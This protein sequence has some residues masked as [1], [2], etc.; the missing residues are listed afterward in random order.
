MAEEA[1]ILIIDDEEV[2]RESCCRILSEEGHQIETATDGERGLQKVKQ[3]KPDLALVDLKMPGM[4]GIEILE[5]IQDIDPDIVSIVITGYATIESAVEAMKR[6]AYDFIPKPFTPDQLR[7]IIRRGLEKRN[8]ALDS[9]RLRHEKNKMRENFITLVSHQLR[10]PLVSIQQYFEVILGGFAGEVHNKQK[11]MLKEASGRIDE[12]IKFINNWLNMTR[13][14]AGNLVGKF[15]PVTL[16]SVV[17]Q[18]VELMR[19]AAEARKVMLRMDFPDSL[20]PITGCEESLKQ[21]FMNII[22]NGINYNREGGTA[23][24]KGRENGDFIVVEISDTGI[25]IAT[26]NLPFI[27]DEFFRVKAKETQNISG[28]GLGLPIAKR[29]IEAHQGSVRV[30]SESDKGTTISVLLPKTG[31]KP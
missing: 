26:E 7:I 31:L 16:S 18:T 28:T 25:G 1:K 21:A 24:I 27:F 13:I 22:S 30:K 10:S 23:T 11:E 19:P 9:A 14:E 15:R 8:L 12:L 2:V 6:N 3:L 4:D 5:K 17:S 29:I 20:A